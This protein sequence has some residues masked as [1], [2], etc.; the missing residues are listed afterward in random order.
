MDYA[1]RPEGALGGC[2]ARTAHP[3]GAHAAAWRGVGR[4][5]D[6]QAVHPLIVE[7]LLGVAKPSQDE[8]SVGVFEIAAARIRIRNSKWGN[9]NNLLPMIRGPEKPRERRTTAVAISNA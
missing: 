5:G 8:G 6:C 7:R 1:A 3:R 4:V 9:S 2:T